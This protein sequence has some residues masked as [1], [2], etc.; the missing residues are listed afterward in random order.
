MLGVLLR[1]CLNCSVLPE[2]LGQL[3]YLGAI[4]FHHLK[5][6]VDLCH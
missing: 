5:H 4:V 6:L 2:Q 1:S 3:S